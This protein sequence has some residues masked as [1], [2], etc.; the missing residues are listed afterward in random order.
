M[1]I[2]WVDETEGLI[3]ARM[4]G[5]GFGGSVIGLTT[6]DDLNSFKINRKIAFS[7][8]WYRTTNLYQSAV[9]WCY[10]YKM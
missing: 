1:V 5:G 6:S 2:N 8:N 10:I 7:R 4:T 3:G 9:R